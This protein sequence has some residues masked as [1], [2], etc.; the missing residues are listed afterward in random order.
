LSQ[1]SEA[2]IDSGRWTKQVEVGGKRKKCVFSLPDLLAPPDRAEWMRR[3]FIPES[4]A[5]VQAN[6]M[7]QEIISSSGPQLTMDELNKTL[8]AEF[9]KPIPEVR[10]LPRNTPAERAEAL[11]AEAVESIG[12]RRVL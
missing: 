9:S 3:G 5:P 12:R 6:A 1:T 11:F 2:E 10:E 8:Q 7:I 4:Y